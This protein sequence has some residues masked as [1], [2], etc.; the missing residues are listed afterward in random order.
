MNLCCLVR[1]VCIIGVSCHKYHFC[2][3]KSMLVVTNIFLSWHICHDNYIFVMTI[4]LLWQVFVVTKQN[5]CRSK[6]V[7]VMTKLLPR[8]TCFCRDKYLLQRKFCYNKNVLV[9]QNICR[10]KHTFVATKDV[11]HNK[12]ILVA[13]PAS[14]TFVEAYSVTL[15]LL[16]S[17]SVFVLVL[18]FLSPSLFME[19]LPRQLAQSMEEFVCVFTVCFFSPH[20]YC[21]FWSSW[22]HPRYSY[23]LIFGF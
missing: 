4:F 2:R 11:F 10:G 21:S 5:F 8:Q 7:L 6:S 15:I 1:C 23:H 13:A 18:V 20:C 22:N 16:D 3:D 17:W 12:V 14:D 9:W 19:G